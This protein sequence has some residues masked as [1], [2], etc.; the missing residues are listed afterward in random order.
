[1][2]QLMGDPGGGPA[3]PWSHLEFSTPDGRL[4]CHPSDPLP[5]LHS[6]SSV[7]APRSH[8][9]SRH[10][11]V[12]TFSTT[13]TDVVAVESGLEQELVLVLDRDP[14]QARL[15]GQPLTVEWSGQRGSAR[16]HTPDL[17][18]L[19][20]DGSVTVWDVR[21]EGRRDREF[22]DAVRCTRAV[23]EHYG[24]GYEL[25]GGLPEVHA[26]N[27]RWLSSYRHPMPWYQDKR[28]T[29]EGLARIDGTTV[30]TVLGTDDGSGELVSAMWHWAWDGHLQL[31]LTQPWRAT[32]PV[33]WEPR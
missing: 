16:R 31:D 12:H 32:T 10:V 5:D 21:P 7:R 30:G 11:P 27:L 13:N 2:S 17:L 29:L 24:W 1:M 28:S 25:F 8:A 23:C 15:V 4:L 22:W 3:T 33:R 26:I 9:L 6:I 18:A 20:Q 19:A 14:S